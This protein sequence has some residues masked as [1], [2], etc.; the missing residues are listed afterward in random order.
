LADSLSRLINV[1]IDAGWPNQET[2]G[3]LDN[4]AGALHESKEHPNQAIQ[5]KMPQMILQICH[6]FAST[7]IYYGKLTAKSVPWI[8][9][10]SS[11]VNS[12]QLRIKQSQEPLKGLMI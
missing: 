11:G 7:G 12:E 8:D 2:L 1:L 5:G 3:V 6:S 4:L 9:S 10:M